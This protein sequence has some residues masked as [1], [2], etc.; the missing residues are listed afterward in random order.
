[1]EEGC[2]WKFTFEEDGKVGEGGQWG[3]G[4]EVGEERRR[5]R[6]LLMETG[7]RE[8]VEAS[9]WDWIWGVGFKEADAE[10]R[11]AEWGRIFWGSV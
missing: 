7:E 2:F 9:P 1:M 3:L 5:V 4:R 10:D 11:R 8:L 6:G